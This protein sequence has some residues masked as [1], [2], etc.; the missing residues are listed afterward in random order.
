MLWGREKEGKEWTTYGAVIESSFLLRMGS[1]MLTEWAL[2]SAGDEGVSFFLLLCLWWCCVV[3]WCCWEGRS[4][5]DG[6]REG[7]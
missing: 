1:D 4:G 7:D 2:G 6:E 5:F 3:L